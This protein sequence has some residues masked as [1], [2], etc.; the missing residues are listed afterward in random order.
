MRASQ[1]VAVALV[2]GAL[3]TVIGVR[4]WLNSPDAESAATQ[5]NVQVTTSGRDAVP[6][7]AEA[8]AAEQPPAPTAVAATAAPA[9]P[10]PTPPDS[11]GPATAKPAATNP[12]SLEARMAEAASESAH[13]TE[14]FL[15]SRRDDGQHAE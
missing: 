10:A 4:V 8:A 12:A 13:R 5:T 2:G 1:I 3:L 14:R 15:H 6:S 11:A 9:S 7:A